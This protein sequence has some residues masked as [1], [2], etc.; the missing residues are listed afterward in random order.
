MEDLTV[1]VSDGVGFFPGVVSDI[2]RFGIKIKDLPKRINAEAQR[3]TIVVSG[4][5]GHFKMKVRP[6]WAK[7]T[8]HIKIIGAEISNVPWGWTEFV[9]GLEPIFQDEVWGSLRL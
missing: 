1:D 6:R 7:G 5:S 8:G 3:L 9:M 4:R 2:S